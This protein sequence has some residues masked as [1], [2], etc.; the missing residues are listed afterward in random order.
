MKQLNLEN[1][2]VFIAPHTPRTTMFKNDLLE[3]YENIKII[4]FIDKTKEADNIQKIEN[5]YQFK[6]DYILILSL[7]H[8]D[9]IYEDYIKLINPSKLL[10]VTIKNENY[11]F[12]NSSEI[13]K[14]KRQNLPQKFKEKSLKL[15]N[16]IL[17]TLSFKRKK[18]VF[19]SKS[20]IGTN[21]K[22]LY[23]ESLN[24]K[25]DSIILT[26]NKEQFKILKKYNLPVCK[27][28]SLKAYYHLALANIVIQDQGNSNNLLKFLSKK[29][30]T[31]QLWHGIP[32]KRMNRL[33]DVMYDYFTSPSKYVNETSLNA[34][35]PSKKQFE[36]GYPRNDLLIKEHNKLDLLFCDVFL[37]KFSKNEKTIVYMPTHRESSSGIDKNVTRLIP[38]DFLQLN[39]CMIELNTYFIVKLHPF[40]MQFYEDIKN[41]KEFSN[42]LF[43]PIE[44]DIYPLLKYTDILVTDYSSVYFD[45]L[46]LNRPI[47]FFDYD[48]EEYSENMGGFVYDYETFTPGIKVQNQQKLEDALQTLIK[49]NTDNFGKQRE[50]LLQQFFTHCNALSSNRIIQEVM[51]NL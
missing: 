1:K 43:Y 18:Y 30:K 32:L 17:D 6:Y 22:M 10:K 3:K 25:L 45:Y 21:N 36:T 9:A 46:L 31:L 5:I 35:I 19:L 2:K 44:G 41:S 28:N 38:L 16:I 50:L 13:R 15:L 23:L 47:I 40:V 49:Y 27:L 37:Y 34:V 48:Y 42:V 26:D 14:E 11:F 51:G 33:T 20:F 39:R 8:F 7:N 24:H 12:I 4:G 29:Q